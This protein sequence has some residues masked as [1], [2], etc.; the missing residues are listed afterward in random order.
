MKETG[1]QHKYVVERGRTTASGYHMSARSSNA[2]KNLQKI[3]TAHLFLLISQV[4]QSQLCLF[5]HNI[6]LEIMVR[7]EFTEDPIL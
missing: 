4:D 2:Y 5:K 1:P 6:Y 3:I 7:V